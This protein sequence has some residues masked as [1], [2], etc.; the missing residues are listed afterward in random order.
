MLSVL[1]GAQYSASGVGQLC[2]V[3]AASPGDE[4]DPISEV[5]SAD[6]ASRY[7]IPP[8]VIPERGKVREHDSE[9]S[10]DKLRG[11]FEN[12]PCGQAYTDKPSVLCPQPRARAI[13]ASTFPTTGNVLTGETTAEQGRALGSAL[14]C[15][16]FR[17]HRRGCR[18]CTV[19]LGDSQ[20]TRSRDSRSD[21]RRRDNANIVETSCMWPVPFKHLMT[22]L[23]KLNLGCY[24]AKPRPFQPHF[25]PT[26]A[27][28]Q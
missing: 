22:V 9:S 12:D 13:D 24:G 2:G 19:G 7:T 23:V 27:A 26:Y 11:V 21:V 10:L 15:V 6:G 5:R 16:D 20:S 3:R 18:D 28:K 4:E 8:R 25:K 14:G 1:F 17:S